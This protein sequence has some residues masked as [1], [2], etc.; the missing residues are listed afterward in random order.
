[1]DQKSLEKIY[2]IKTRS[3]ER[4]PIIYQTINWQFIADFL[5]KLD[6]FVELSEIKEGMNEKGNIEIKS[7]L[8]EIKAI[9]FENLCDLLNCT[10]KIFFDFKLNADNKELF[11]TIPISTYYSSKS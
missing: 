2:E 10:K 9:S 8:G 7:N 4:Q 3:V 11:L 1:M 5:T 6:K